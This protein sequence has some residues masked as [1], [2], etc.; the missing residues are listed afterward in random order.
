MGAEK[1]FLFTLTLGQAHE[2]PSAIT[3]LEALPRRPR[4]VVCDRGYAS[5]RFR[6][7]HC[8]RGSRPVIPPKRNEPSAAC[9]KWA[10]RHRHLVENLWTRLKEG[11]AVATQYEKT[12]A[13]FI[14]V[15][16][17]AATEDYLK[18]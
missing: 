5:N 11:R 7:E 15:I 14:S 16:C 2:L 9:P 6:E 12:A 8:D 17:I 1:P 4:Y 13:S 10:Y 18:S 3:L